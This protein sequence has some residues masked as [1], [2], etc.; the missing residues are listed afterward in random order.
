M[1]EMDSEVS[2]VWQAV[3]ENHA[4]WLAD[5]ILHFDLTHENLAKELSVVSTCL[6][7][8]SRCV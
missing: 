4:E 1:I 3:V 8:T 7:Y 5:R 2:A 6:L